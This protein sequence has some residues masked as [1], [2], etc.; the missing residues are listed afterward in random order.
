MFIR[1]GTIHLPF[2]R[3]TVGA[4]RNRRGRG[5]TDGGD[6]IALDDHGR[7]RHARVRRCRLTTDAP[8]MAVVAAPPAAPRRDRRQRGT[9]ADARTTAA[10]R[11]RAM[12]RDERDCKTLPV[13]ARVPPAASV[14]ATLA[15]NRTFTPNRT[16]RGG[17]NSDHA[18]E[19][20]AGERIHARDRV[21]VGGVE[22]VERERRVQTRRSA[23]RS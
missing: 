6:A 20:G 11:D 8:T 17:T 13:E 15:Q 9:S 12:A 16:T 7:I 5:R 22:D 23:G 14:T 18:I 21:G 2:A 4:L 19:G 1:P 3:M 10:G